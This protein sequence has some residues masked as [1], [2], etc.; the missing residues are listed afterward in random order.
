MT[1]DFGQLN[2]REVKAL[3]AVTLTGC[4]KGAAKIL[5]VS[6]RTIEDYMLAARRKTGAKNRVL[7]VLEWDRAKRSTQ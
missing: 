6:T 3:D 7:L 2:T 5:E 1:C 4:N